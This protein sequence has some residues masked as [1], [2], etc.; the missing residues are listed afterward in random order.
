MR[1]VKKRKNI[2]QIRMKHVFL[3]K[4]NWHIVAQILS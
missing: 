3:K 1:Y 4:I 2:F